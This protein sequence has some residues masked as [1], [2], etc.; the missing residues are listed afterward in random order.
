[1]NLLNQDQHKR[2]FDFTSKRPNAAEGAS[3]QGPSAYGLGPEQEDPV[4]HNASFTDKKPAPA[5]WVLMNSKH[6][7]NKS[8]SKIG[9]PHKN[10][11]PSGIGQQVT[12]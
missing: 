2:S 4:A 1:M 5:K 8:E 7:R 9:Q 6:L 11:A 3:R 12:P 10:A